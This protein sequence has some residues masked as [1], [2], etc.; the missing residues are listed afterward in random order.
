[1]CTCILTWTCVHVRRE[2]ALCQAKLQQHAAFHAFG[3]R[4]EQ[5][6]GTDLCAASL[7][8][9]GRLR[10]PLNASPVCGGA[11]SMQG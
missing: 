8:E 6:P 2:G 10:H 1:M 5:S 7:V 4:A 11:V 9:P 3:T